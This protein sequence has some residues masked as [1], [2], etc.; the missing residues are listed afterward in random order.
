MAVNLVYIVWRGNLG[1]YVPQHVPNL[2]RS[3]VILHTV[4][5]HEF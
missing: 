4:M 3:Q 2:L 1:R 5:T